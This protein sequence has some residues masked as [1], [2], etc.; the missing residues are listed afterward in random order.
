MVVGGLEFLQ[1]MID[2]IITKITHSLTANKKRGKP[3]FMCI[4]DNVKKAGHLRI[5]QL[6]HSGEKSFTCETCF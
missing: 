2:G 5:H 4:I 3:I 6:T 1:R